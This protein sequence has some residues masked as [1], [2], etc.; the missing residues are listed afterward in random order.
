LLIM[1]GMELSR[2]VGGPNLAGRGSGPAFR[3]KNGFVVYA[4]TVGIRFSR[5]I[6]GSSFHV[7]GVRSRSG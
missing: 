2:F 5:R 4:E 1:R 6:S 3:S 7:R